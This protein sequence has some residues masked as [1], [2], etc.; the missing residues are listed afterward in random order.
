M[1]SNLCVLPLT[2]VAIRLRVGWY[3]FFRDDPAKWLKCTEQQPV[4]ELQYV[5]IGYNYQCFRLEFSTDFSSY[6]C[7]VRDERR[8]KVFIANFTGML[9]LLSRLFCYK[10][11]KWTC[12]VIEVS[13]TL[14]NLISV[15]HNNVRCLRRISCHF[16]EIFRYKHCLICI[17]WVFYAN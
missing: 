10:S 17:F 8:C 14:V 12:I 3:F 6:T 13:S 15:I 9:S 7:V 4:T 1:F 2:E 16:L 5:D 11:R